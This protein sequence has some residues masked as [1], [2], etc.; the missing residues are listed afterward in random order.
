MCFRVGAHVCA[1]VCVHAIVSVTVLHKRICT[2]LY[3]RLRW[4]CAYV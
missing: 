3:V 4:E 1:C 2:S